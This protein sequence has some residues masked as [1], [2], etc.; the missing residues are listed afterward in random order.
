LCV[1][2]VIYQNQHTYVCSFYVKRLSRKN[3]NTQQSVPKHDNTA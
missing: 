2:L 1:K 3:V